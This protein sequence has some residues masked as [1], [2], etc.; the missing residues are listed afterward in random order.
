MGSPLSPPQARVLVASGEEVLARS[1]ET[2]LAPAGFVVMQAFTG[3]A[4]L[5]LARHDPP[6]A[7][8]L[9]LQAPEI[10]GLSVCR[11]L[12]AATY[13]TAATPIMLITAGA[14]TRQMRLDALRAGA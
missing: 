13:V 8:I 6:D 2:I 12:R 5:H 3:E 1:I 14:A 10:A 9:D 7:F 11:A 4:A